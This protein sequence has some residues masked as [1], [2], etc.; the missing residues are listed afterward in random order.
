MQRNR[1]K[2]IS[3]V[4][5]IV[6]LLIFILIYLVWNFLIFIGKIDSDEKIGIIDG[7]LSKSYTSV[8]SIESESEKN[9]EHETHGDSLL[10][11]I[12]QCNDNA[13]VYYYN[14]ENAEGKIT[15]DGIVNGLNWMVEN[16]VKKVNISLSNKKK[17]LELEKW[18]DEHKNTIKVFASYNNVHN[19][20]D[21]PAMFK[22]V[23]AS[24]TD[25]NIDYKSIDFH[26]RSN[27]IVMCHSLKR[28]ML[29]QGN[30]FLSVYSMMKN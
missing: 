12:F 13:N 5:L 20:N 14:A 3:I 25:N 7:G 30:S 6:I 21:Y 1:K 19:T 17:H 23:Y 8:V 26:Y 22:N 15:N 11:F 4:C 24:G 28:I 10:E 27:R 2:T 18:I 9:V 29:Y 16:S